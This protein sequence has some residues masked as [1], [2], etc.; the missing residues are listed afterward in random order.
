MKRDEALSKARAFKRELLKRGLPVR[1]VLLFGSVA[2]GT[3]DRRSDIDLAVVCDAF[4]PTRHEENVEVS[5]ARW[6]VD[7]RIQTFCLHPEDMEN[8][9][10]T[11]AQEVKKHGISV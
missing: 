5:T 8:T 4:L 3:A 10:S 6:N 1:Q 2:K 7:L 11:I 9:Y